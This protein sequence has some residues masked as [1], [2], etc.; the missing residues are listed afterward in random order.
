[1][2][3]ADYLMQG[4]FGLGLY[5]GISS[6]YQIDACAWTGKGTGK[7]AAAQAEGKDAVAAERPAGAGSGRGRTCRR[8]CRRQGRTCAGSEGGRR[9][10]G[11]QGRRQERA[12]GR[13]GGQGARPA[14]LALVQG[15]AKIKRSCKGCGGAKAGAAAGEDSRR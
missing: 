3:H 11:H 1:M 2:L 7:A 14:E 8:G 4:R 10:G 5:W 13:Q 12:G 6:Q 9:Q 15:A